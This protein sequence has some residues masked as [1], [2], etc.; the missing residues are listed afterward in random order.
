MSTFA[1]KIKTSL[2]ETRMLMLGTQVLISLQFE[3]T[4]E[5]RFTDLPV[6]DRDLICVALA[7]LLVTFSILLWGPAYH[8]IVYDGAFN[9]HVD[10]FMTRGIVLALTPIGVAVAIDLFIAVHKI[11]GLAAGIGAGLLSL[12][13]AG[14]LW[15]ALGGGRHA[16][17]SSAADGRGQAAGPHRVSSAS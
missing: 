8:R 13:L 10:R 9:K 12:G 15:Y 7:M 16:F 14:T 11:I 3:S 6:P 1:D 4:F 5:G 17:A 2:N